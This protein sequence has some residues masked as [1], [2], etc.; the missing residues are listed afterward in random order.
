MRQSGWSGSL[1]LVLARTVSLLVLVPVLALGAAVQFSSGA[2][3][4]STP[5]ASPRTN[6]YGG[7]ADMAA[8][9]MGGYWTATWAGAVTPH[10][11]APALGSPA[12]SGLQLT[13]PTIGMA[14]TPDGRGY[15]LVASDGGIFN[16]GDA[17]FYGSAGGMQL[18]QPIVGM[19]PTTDG[20]GYWLVASDGGTFSYGD[21]VFY[22][23]T[24]AI[25]LNKPIVGMAP[26][27]DGA[28][29][30]LVA[31]DGGI[32][33]YGD[34]AFHGSTGAIRLNEPIIGMA[35]TA[36]G[37]GYWLV[38][39]DG[40]VFTFGDAGY[41]GSTAG[42]GVPALGILID[43]PSAGY[44]VVTEDGTE[45]PFGPSA[46][47]GNVQPTG[48]GRSG[49]TT[50][51]GPTTTTTR[52]PRTT[53]TTTTTR[54]PSTTSTTA[55]ANPPANP[56]ASPTSGLQQG[57][58]V[59]AGDPSGMASFAQQTSTTPTVAT[60]YLPSNNGWS[61]M[62]G[63]G[64]SLN[65]LTGAW[66]G[67][68][69]TLS[70][71]VPIIPDS[72]SGPA[73]GTLAQG[74]TGEYNLYFITLAQTLVSGGEANAY[75]RLGFEFD[76]AWMPWA[77]ATPSDEANFAAYF[78]Q[79]VTAMRAVPGENFHFVWNPDAAAFTQSGYSVAA[80]YPGNAYVDV[81]GLDAY[82]QSWATPQ[83]P[84]NAWSS[85]TLPA[86]TAAR[87]FA[88]AQGKPLA[89]TEWG[90]IIRSD[91][92]GLGDDPTYINQMVSWMKNSA[93]NVTYE[94]YFDYDPSG[95]DSQITGGLF[96]NSLA[97]FAADLG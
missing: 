65:W 46:P 2:G 4:A 20:R 23:S 19:A 88:S 54:A 17:T 40:G 93:N 78:Q 41:Y 7:G 44:A 50:T 87:Q 31:S 16:Y 25:H 26:T 71:G 13:R 95:L 35:P 37:A 32:F 42:S 34:A 12:Q 63:A 56:P 62:D 5:A 92:H 18:N 66:K 75:L 85:T 94:T 97:A 52:P 77:A 74:A 86:L 61:G 15:W 55:A 47:N 90:V 3:A 72:S 28:G 96:P 14:A 6:G 68:G 82:D 91:G 36:D 11:S 22:G 60:D 70:L 1:A 80:A 49:T 81:I 48:S 53:T 57:A 89:L 38:A 64:G 58:Y 84:A 33:S 10:G 39:S 79:I 30:W 51:T 67:T 8:D 27:I 29:Y 24:G 76:G 83:T 9:P 73:V 69:Y 43:P 45:T 59:G 21:A